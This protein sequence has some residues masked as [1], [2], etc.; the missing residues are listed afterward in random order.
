MAWLILL[1]LAFVAFSYL[2]L[3]GENLDY[4]DS[5]I[6]PVA[7]GDPGE[8]HRQVV[9]SLSELTSSGMGLGGGKG[10]LKRIREYM[11][12]M[13]DNRDYPSEFRPVDEVSVKGE[14]ILAPGADPRRRLLHIHGGAWMMG[15]PKSHRTITSR[16]SELANA[17]V[18]S[19]DY[20]LLPENKRLDGI[21]DCQRAYSWILDNGP[22]GP[23][24][25]DFLMVSGD[26]AGGNLTLMT[27]AWAR[28]T[29]LRAADAAVAFSP[30]TDVTLTAPS[31]RTNIATDP[32]LGPAFGS[33]AKIPTILLWW[34]TWFT[35]RLKP[36]DPLASPVRG[37][38]SGLPPV[39]LQVSEAEMLFDD[40]RRYVA[41]A[42]AAGTHAVLQSWPHM[43][44][45]WQIFSPDLP[46]AEEAFIAVGEFLDSVE[47][48]SAVEANAA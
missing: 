28:D 4:L 38:L 32:M 25:L 11:D 1:V 48:A 18:F 42:Q 34:S 17:A 14:W 44:H 39:L 30:A 8:P 33:L 20:R 47:S 27:I 16:L 19:I 41:K 13:T 7:E 3:R 46:Q 21:V 24:E 31:L 2:V 23:E 15:S 6:T 40:S 10:G 45:V 43:V 29:G 36:S 26:S 5:N 22:D 12:S 35:S 37:D 9:A